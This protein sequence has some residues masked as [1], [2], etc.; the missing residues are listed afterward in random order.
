VQTQGH[1]PKRRNGKI[2]FRNGKQCGLEGRMGELEKSEK[3]NVVMVL[4]K[5]DS[6]K[7]TTF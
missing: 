2:G 6:A 3:Q 5:I 1:H 4:K 7:K